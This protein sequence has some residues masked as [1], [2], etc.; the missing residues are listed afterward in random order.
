MMV[1]FVSDKDILHRCLAKQSPGE[2]AGKRLLQ[3]GKPTC[4]RYNTRW[5]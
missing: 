2:T 5:P 1:K 3:R 4:V